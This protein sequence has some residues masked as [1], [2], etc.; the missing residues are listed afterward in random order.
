MHP[1]KENFI[2]QGFSV[3]HYAN[4]VGV[5]KAILS[6]LLNGKFAPTP[7]ANAP[8]FNNMLKQLKKD[9]VLKD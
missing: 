6:R 7:K 5:D 8:K 1:L 3:T 4:K 9:G 2:K